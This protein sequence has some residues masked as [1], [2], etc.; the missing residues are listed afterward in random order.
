MR[1]RR[2]PWVSKVRRGTPVRWDKVCGSVELG[3]GSCWVSGRVSRGAQGASLGGPTETRSQ[4]KCPG[5]ILDFPMADMESMKH[6]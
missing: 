1:T 5:S 4:A 6:F 2:R 3:A